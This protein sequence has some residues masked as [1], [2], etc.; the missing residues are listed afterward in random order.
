MDK[1]EIYQIIKRHYG[2]YWNRKETELVEP[3]SAV[4]ESISEEIEYKLG[5]KEQ[6]LA[7]QTKENN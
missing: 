1:N 3:E 2:D 5:E 7:D 6:E 4:W